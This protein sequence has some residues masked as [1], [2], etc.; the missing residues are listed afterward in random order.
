[1]E[2]KKIHNQKLEELAKYIEEQGSN[3]NDLIMILHKAQ[4]LF[5]YLSEE[6]ILFLSEKLS[7]PAAKIYGVITFYSHFSTEPKGKHVI[8]VCMGTACFVRGSQ[9]VLDEFKRELKI[10]VG[11]TTEDSMFSLEA[12]RCVGT[13]GLA[14][15]I[16][17]N[18]KVY[19][20][21]KRED[22]KKI[23][24]EYKGEKQ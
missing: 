17:V 7:I 10:D 2:C 1:M 9:D 23:I 4:E 3:K 20:H 18:E 24:A 16:S 11:E 22:V 21:V 15:V 19:G 6:V 5:G 14:P 13:C 8:N 12:L